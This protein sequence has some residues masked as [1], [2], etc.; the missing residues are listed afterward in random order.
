MVGVNPHLETNLKGILIKCQTSR[1]TRPIWMIWF[2]WFLWFFILKSKIRWRFLALFCSVIQWRLNAIP[3]AEGRGIIIYIYTVNKSQ[4]FSQ[5]KK[6]ECRSFSKT[7]FFE[8][9]FGAGDLALGC[10]SEGSRDKIYDLRMGKNL[11]FHLH[12]SSFAVPTIAKSNQT[13]ESRQAVD[14]QLIFWWEWLNKKTH[15][16]WS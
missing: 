2:L 1:L 11:W 9:T 14:Q 5:K 16:S 4:R 13:F 12:L 6:T 15:R 10:N 8:L 3:N 7:L